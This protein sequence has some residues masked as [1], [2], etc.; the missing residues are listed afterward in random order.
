M[1][2][3]QVVQGSDLCST[4]RTVA[5][6]SFLRPFSCAG[7]LYLLAQWTGISTMVFYMT[8]IF[9][10]SGSTFDPLLAPVIVAGIR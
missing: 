6:S 8:N 1:R 9:Q 7:L 3:Q 10:Q 5:S 2:N 4:L